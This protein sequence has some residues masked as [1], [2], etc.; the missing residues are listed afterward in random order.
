MARDEDGFEVGEVECTK[1]TGLSLL[2][3]VLESSCTL[4]EGEDF[5]VP[6]SQVHDD[7]EVYQLGDR[8]KLIVSNWLADERGWSDK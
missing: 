5:W 8:G 3:K 1:G 6:L 7:S 2:C 4:K